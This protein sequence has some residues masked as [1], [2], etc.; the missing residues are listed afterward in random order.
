M[1]ALRLVTIIVIALL[2]L[3]SANASAAPPLT[4]I[5]DTLYKADGTPFT[6][7]VTISWRSFVAA[8]STSIPTNSITV[9]INGGVLS[10]RLVPTVNAYGTA[11][12][13]VRF[14]ADGQ[15]QFNQIWSVPATSAPVTLKDIRLDA[16][17]GSTSQVPPSTVQMSDVTGLLDALNDRVTRSVAWL[18][19][20]AAWIDLNG[21]L[22]SVSGAPGDCVRVDG[23]AGPCG[24]T[25]TLPGFVDMET[26]T[27][28]V[29]GS[30]L[31]FTLNQAPAPAASLHLFRNGVLQRPSVDYTINGNILTFLAAAAPQSSD[32]LLASYRTAGQ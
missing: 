12:Y 13:M 14:N 7:T 26:P 21:E 6:G 22:A 11:Y 31:V 19:G 27:G 18:A 9:R 2:A 5:S 10:L 1:P 24:T 28:T 32:L 20:R 16:P 17:P 29:N 4:R 23:S 3:A 25:V 30:N 15:V 8:N